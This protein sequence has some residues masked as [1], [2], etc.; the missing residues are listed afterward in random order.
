MISGAMDLD[1]DR[2]LR[3]AK[4]PV[5]VIVTALYL[6]NNPRDILVAV[7]RVP[8]INRSLIENVGNIGLR[9]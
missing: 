3:V 2:E 5:T 7:L 4:N 6:I 1:L 8:I 9:R